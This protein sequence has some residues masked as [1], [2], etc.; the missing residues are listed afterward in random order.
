M[1]GPQQL[2]VLA[3]LLIAMPAAA[4]QNTIPNFGMDS[5]IGWVA[6]VPG[7]NEPIGDDFL[8]PPEGPGP[9]VSDKDHPYIDNTYAARTGRQPT[10]HVADLGNPILQPWA[11]EE[12]RKVNERVLNGEPVFTP[13]ERCW[14][15]GVPAFLLYPVTPVYFLQT[16]DEVTL[17][18]QEDHMVRHIYLNRQHSKNVTPSWFGESIGHYEGGDTLVVDTIGLNTRTFVDQFRT[19]HSLQLHVIERFHIL[20]GGNAMEAT[21]TVED[22][23]AFTTTWR[24]VQKYRRVDQGPM[25]ENNCA[26]NNASFFGLDVEPIPTAAKAD[27]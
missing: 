25:I 5:R 14:P 18:W 21:A 3:V 2:A 9:V 16:P 1:P 27:F 7:S 12:L 24:A 6:G 23:G 17:I 10:F 11:R 15:I 13:K 22:P 19:P 20:P 26:E 4:Q 8:P